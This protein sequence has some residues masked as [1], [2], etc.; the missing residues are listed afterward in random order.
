MFFSL[1]L[2]GIIYWTFKNIPLKMTKGG[3]KLY[4]YVRNRGARSMCTCA[5]DGGGGSNFCH[6]GA[7]VLIE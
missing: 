5:Y 7:Y 6:F 4:E 2:Y 3:L 1:F